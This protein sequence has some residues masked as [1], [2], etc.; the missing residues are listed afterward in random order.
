VVERVMLRIAPQRDVVEQLGLAVRG[1]NGT[2][3]HQAAVQR[4][5]GRALRER[6][7]FIEDRSRDVAPWLCDAASARYVIDMKRPPRERRVVPVKDPG[8]MLQRT[9]RRP[10]PSQVTA[11]ANAIMQM[12]SFKP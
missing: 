4:R 2:R 1:Q 12:R 7:Q 5:R 9:G 3:V 6:F 10:A 8:D 11:R